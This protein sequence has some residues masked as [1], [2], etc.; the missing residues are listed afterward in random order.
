VIPF[1]FLILIMILNKETVKINYVVQRAH[2]DGSF[3]D[4]ASNYEG[5]NS[6]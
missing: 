4:A 6:R 1:L 3:S 2:T 5:L